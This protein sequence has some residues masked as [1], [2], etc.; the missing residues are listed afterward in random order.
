M[1]E[2]RPHHARGRENAPHHMVNR[3]FAV[4]MAVAVI[5]MFSVLLMA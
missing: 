5:G 2:F 3:S 1:I 4:A